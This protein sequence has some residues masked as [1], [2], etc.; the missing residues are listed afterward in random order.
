MTNFPYKHVHLVGIKGVAMTALA[1]L[2][3]DYGVAITG[4]DVAADFVTQDILATL[5][6]PVQ[7]SFLE[8]LPE[9]TECVIYTAAHQAVNNPQV[10]LALATGL[11]TFS[12]AEALAI[13]FN[14]KQG[15]AVCG[16]GGK[17]TP[18]AMITWILS[19]V[20]QQPS[21]A[22]GVGDIIGLHKTGFWSNDS[23]F[24]VAEA[25]EY[26]TDP[27]AVQAGEPLIPRFSFLEPQV[28]VCTNVSY[29]HPDVYRDFEQTKTVFNTFFKHIKSGGS[30]VYNSQNKTDLQLP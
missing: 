17:A 13:F 5:N 3:G 30:L 20:G 24:F 15:V 18:S 21:F 4:S 27:A 6:L 14:Q 1:Q 23:T 29:D 7:S 25:D 26:A 10:Q 12:H 28:T 19:Q 16:V 22:V 8:A 11:A 2:L 9:K